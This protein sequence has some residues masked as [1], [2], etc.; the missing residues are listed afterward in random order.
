MSQKTF[1]PIPKTAMDEY[2]LKLSA[3]LQ[4]GQTKAATLSV[5]LINNS[6]RINVWTN[7]NGDK[8]NGRISAPMDSITFIALIGELEKIIDGENDVQV[9]IVNRTGKPGETFVV[10]TTVLGKDKEGRVFI[11]VVAE[12]RPKIKFTF[13]PS[14]WH[15]LTHKDGTPYTESALSVT[16]AKAWSRLLSSLLPTVLTNYY[17]QP[18]PWDGGKKD[19]SSNGKQATTTA[20]KDNEADFDGDDYPM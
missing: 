10:S 14:E 12:N 16:Y 15:M 11:S 9:K 3:P 4:D 8:D 2:K 7:I 18:E 5:G 6:P 19:Y 17:V 20:P 1:K 13:L